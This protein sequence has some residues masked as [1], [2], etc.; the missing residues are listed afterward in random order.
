MSSDRE[1]VGALGVCA[2]P[3]LGKFSSLTEVQRMAIPEIFSGKD[4]M[5]ASATASGK[6]E[7]IVVPIVARIRS[8][9]AFSGKRGV[10]FLIVAPTRALVNDLYTRL[11]TPVSEI[12]W[13]CGR[14]TSDHSDKKRKPHILITTPES[15]DSMLAND[16]SRKDGK[17]V[18]HL[19][20]NVR[21]L[22]L[23]EA[24]LYENSVR[25]E[26]VAWL[27][28]RL[29][30][31][32]KYSFEKGWVSDGALQVCAGSATISNCSDLAN[33]LLGSSSVVIRVG[34]DREIEVFAHATSNSWVSVNSNSGM[35]SMLKMIRSDSGS[36]ESL[37]EFIWDAMKSA[38]E[39]GLRKF[40]IFAPSR[41]QTDLLSAELTTFLESRRNVYVSAHHGSLDKSK[42]EEAEKLFSECRDSVLVA[43]STL[44]V[45][46]D[47]GDVDI[48]VIYGAP[49]DTHALLQRVGR[50]GRR[51]GSIKLV[52]IPRNEIDAVAFAGMI[53]SACRGDLEA[54]P[55][56]RRWSVFVQQTISMILQSGAIG[57]K[58]RDMYEMVESVWGKEEIETAKLVI[59]HL[60][61]EELLFLSNNRLMLGEKFS[62]DVQDYRA[63]FHCNF[64]SGAN[65]MPV[66]DQLTGQTIGH[67]KPGFIGSDP[68]AIGGHA[69]DVLFSGNEV[70]VRTNRKSVSSTF[71]YDSTRIPMSKSFAEHIRRGLGF[72]ENETAL[73]DS[74]K[75]GLLW[76]HFGG[77]IYERAL[78]RLLNSSSLRSV[79]PAGLVLCGNVLIQ[80]VRNLSHRVHDVTKAI[81]EISRSIARYMGV[82]RFHKYLP[83][84]IQSQ[85]I[86]GMFDIESFLKWAVSRTIRRI[87]PASKHSDMIN[88]LLS[89][90]H[91]GQN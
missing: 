87:N 81:D 84:D 42:R 38:A 63:F 30:R 32:R 4:V 72:E 18:G 83:V 70:L 21:A 86:I 77:E 31:L 68:M 23:D 28:N 56:C 10:V 79:T 71:R 82:G 78:L 75:F 67:I 24:H 57:R 8:A 33:R 76:F 58:P 5:L 13:T 26:H 44:E 48:I 14:Q 61:N 80:E 34:G 51:S 16:V 20:E 41:R 49:P 46:I 50:G 7:A 59:N 6:T 2:Q 29:K 55:S 85:V 66:V 36:N 1:I 60:I 22:F 39:Y 73:F 64:D 45:G 40:L 90:C 35:D 11:E 37:C 53:M 88:L 9:R 27:L 12:G 69:V 65:T 19:L 74:E 52:P 91:I 89:D 17:P 25:G 15:L 43:T 47:I 62:D 3:F 54:G